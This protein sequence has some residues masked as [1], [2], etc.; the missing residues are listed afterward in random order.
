MSNIGG[1][2]DIRNGGSRSNVSSG[3]GGSSSSIGG[4][5]GPARYRM[6]LQ[7]HFDKF[8]IYGFETLDSSDT[9]F[10]NR[11]P[12]IVSKSFKAMSENPTFKCTNTQNGYYTFALS[13]GG[14]MLNVTSLMKEIDDVK[15]I[16]E[17]VVDS[18]FEGSPGCIVFIIKKKSF[19]G[20]LSARVHET[21]GT[22][23]VPLGPRPE[24]IDLEKCSD[25]NYFNEETNNDL[26]LIVENIH[27]NVVPIDID[28]SDC[29]KFSYAYVQHSMKL[30]GHRCKGYYDLRKLSALTSNYSAT[31]LNR[32]KSDWNIVELLLDLKTN[33]I[34]IKIS[35]D[36]KTQGDKPFR[37]TREQYTGPQPP[38]LDRSTNK[39]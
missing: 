36:I 27:K 2:S 5:R 24:I 14:G 7:E 28:I 32:R 30:I 21:R 15:D 17:V 35:R 12:G 8:K 18:R 31:A 22:K 37:R 1:S 3:G 11:I 33:E 23:N 20:E 16:R 34:V 9:S 10:A 4:N 6:G 26:V 13:G 19:G 29:W 25:E 39:Q 38:W